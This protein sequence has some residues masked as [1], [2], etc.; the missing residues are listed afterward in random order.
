MGNS[1][2]NNDMYKSCE[3]KYEEV[4]IIIDYL[5]DTY[6]KELL[7]TNFCDDLIDIYYKNKEVKNNTILN[8]LGVDIIPKEKPLNKSELCNTIKDDFSTR[9]GKIKKIYSI[10][11]NI[12]N[13]VITIYNGPLCV[14]NPE[15]FNIDECVKTGSVWKTDVN[16]PD[17]DVNVEWFQHLQ[18]L[19]SLYN[20]GLKYIIGYLKILLQKDTTIE[21]INS[22]VEMVCSEL[23]NLDKSSKQIYKYLLETKTFTKEDVL[24]EKQKEMAIYEALK[25][26]QTTHSVIQNKK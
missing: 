14:D 17:K 5:Y 19:L 24:K 12:K 3:V 6:N 2:S 7:E 21:L 25:K 16:L 9:L 4:K 8:D 15:I 13:R 1:E 26:A 23:I 11:T 10:I 22:V 18:L 20:K